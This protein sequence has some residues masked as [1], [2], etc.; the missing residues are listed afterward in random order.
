M[1]ARAIGLWSEVTGG[2]QG[3]AG[4]AQLAQARTGGC[5]GKLSA[6]TYPVGS[7]WSKW[8]LCIGSLCSSAVGSP[9]AVGWQRRTR[10]L[11]PRHSVRTKSARHPLVVLQ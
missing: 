5:V 10:F 11:H 4:K 6:A 3:V 1:V 8:F 2:D 7:E 9:S